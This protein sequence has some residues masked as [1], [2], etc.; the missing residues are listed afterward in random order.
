LKKIDACMGPLLVR[1]LPAAFQRPFPA[2]VR[3]VLFVR[4]GGIGDAVLLVPTIRSLRKAFPGVVVDVLAERRNSEVF[5]LCSEVDR[6]WC[7][8]LPREL[9]AV[10][11]GRY[12]IVVDTEQWHRLSAVLS[13]LCRA[14]VTVG[15]ATNERFRLFSHVVSYSHHEY[16]IQSFFRLLEPLGVSISRGAEMRVPFLHVSEPPRI[17][18]GELLGEFSGEPL[19]AVFPGA[20]IPERRWGP[21]RFA[22]LALKL[23]KARIKVVVI[24]GKQD[25]P[26]G[27]RIA[28]VVGCADLIGRTSL[29]ESA[30]IIE[31]CDVLVSGD[32]GILHI[33]VGFGKPTV[34]LFGPGIA[35]KWAPRGAKHIVLNQKLPCSPCTRFGYTPKCPR[36]AKCLQAI[37]VDEVTAAVLKLLRRDEK[38]SRH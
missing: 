3:H 30:A 14:R 29:V 24:G 32:S 28:S 17:R 4:P 19:V 12:D 2:E 25:S 16:E 13:R 27:K 11:R 23:T 38:G 31:K 33:G 22:G 36:G 26:D 6:T 34:S 7:Y 8:D 21:E 15:F 18:A 9:F 35:E 5:Q 37:S 1:A 20:S 10:L